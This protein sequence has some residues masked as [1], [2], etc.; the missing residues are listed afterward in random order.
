M[1]IAPNLIEMLTE[2]KQIIPAKLRDFEKV[3]DLEPNRTV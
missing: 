1:Q 2:A 3:H